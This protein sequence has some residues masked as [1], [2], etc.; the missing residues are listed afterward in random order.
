MYFIIKKK[1][2]KVN[3][4]LE[5]FRTVKF[6]RFFLSNS[7]SI[8]FVKLKCTTVIWPS[9]SRITEE[10]NLLYRIVFSS[11]FYPKPPFHQVRICYHDQ[12]V[13]PLPQPCCKVLLLG[14]LLLHKAQKYWSE[15][16]R[17]MQVREFIPKIYMQNQRMVWVYDGP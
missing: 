17:K 5:Y 1:K 2:K 4:T 9:G 3:Q 16:L 8:M 13:L 12:H 15:L 11:V 10:I 7:V 14:F 6:I